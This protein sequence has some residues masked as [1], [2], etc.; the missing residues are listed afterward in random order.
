[1]QTEQSNVLRLPDV[2][3]RIG[4]SKPSIYRLEKEGRF[5]KRIKLSASA[6]GYLECEVDAWLAGRIAE[7]DQR[8]AA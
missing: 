2:V 8:G 7:R 5:P 1:M 4:L 3:R 6:S